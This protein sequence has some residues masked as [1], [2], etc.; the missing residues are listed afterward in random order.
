MDVD[1]MDNENE[2]RQ[3]KHGL[4]MLSEMLDMTDNGDCIEDFDECPS[5]CHIISTLTVLLRSWIDGLQWKLE[6]K[7]HGVLKA[8]GLHID[9]MYRKG[10]DDD[11]RR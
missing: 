5:M 4:R 2:T 11:V 9:R 7:E 3:L 10:D 1:T 8:M 6:V